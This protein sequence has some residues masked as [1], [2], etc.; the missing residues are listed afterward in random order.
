[1]AANKG[2]DALAIQE[3]SAV[4]VEKND[5][6]DALH[7]A[8]QFHREV[9]DSAAVV[10]I[11]DRFY[12]FISAGEIPSEG[13]YPTPEFKRSPYRERSGAAVEK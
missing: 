10:K 4:E 1:M 13:L 3:R 11:A 8:M 12:R 2:G 6:K 5:R 7:F 9:E